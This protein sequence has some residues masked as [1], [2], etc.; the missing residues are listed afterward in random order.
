LK[1]FHT[2]KILHYKILYLK[3]PKHI[4]V[5]APT[6]PANYKRTILITGASDGLGKQLAIELASKVRE[7]FVIVHGRTQRGCEKTL[8]EIAI[9]QKVLAPSNVAFIVADFGDFEQVKRLPTPFF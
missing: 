2:S 8:Q 9:E 4:S 1:K 3:K 5:F 7:N 6:Q